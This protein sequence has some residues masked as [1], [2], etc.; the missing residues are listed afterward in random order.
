MTQ[1]KPR[2]DADKDGF[3]SENSLINPQRPDHQK[4]TSVSSLNDALSV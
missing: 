4:V 2:M 1:L 3:G